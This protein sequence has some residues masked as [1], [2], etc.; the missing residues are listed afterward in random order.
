NTVAPLLTAGV[1]DHLHIGHTQVAVLFLARCFFHLTFFL[2]LGLFLGLGF[3]VSRSSDRYLM[4]NVF[5]Q[6]NATAAQSPR[7]TVLPCDGELT[8]FIA[9]LQTAG[10]GLCVAHGLMLWLF[11]GGGRVRAV[12]K[13]G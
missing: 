11:L 4:T 13:R 9:L 6:L 2:F 12:R 10:Y 7:L 1:A 8:W 5:V 3:A